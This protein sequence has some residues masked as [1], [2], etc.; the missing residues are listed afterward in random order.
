MTRTNPPTDSEMDE[1]LRAWRLAVSQLEVEFAACRD[2]IADV[3]MMVRQGASRRESAVRLASAREQMLAAL[4]EIQSAYEDS[5]H[6][7][8]R[9]VTEHTKTHQEIVMEFREGTESLIERLR[10]HVH[11]VGGHVRIAP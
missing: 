1:R 6:E 10:A 2:T 8:R 9:F 4:R 5:M 11:S 3:D 7:Y